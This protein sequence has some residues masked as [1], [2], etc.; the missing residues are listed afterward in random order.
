MI[1]GKIEV[2]KDNTKEVLSELQ[3]KIK[4]ALESIGSTGES[5]AK[6]LCPVGTP[7]ST[8]IAGYIG[9]TLRNSIAHQVEGNTVY[10][11]TAVDYGIYVEMGARG[12]DPRPFIEPAIKGH[13]EEYRLIVQNELKD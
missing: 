9:G 6:L 10:V 13:L 1:S 7:E 4:R 8:G 3:N 5:Y 11:G 2:K 12:K